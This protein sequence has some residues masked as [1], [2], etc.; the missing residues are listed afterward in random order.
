MLKL[1][2]FYL[3]DILVSRY[4]QKIYKKNPPGMGGVL[5][6]GPTNTGKDYILKI[7]MA[8][9]GYR[10]DK[11]YCSLNAGPFVDI[12]DVK[13]KALIQSLILHIAEID[14]WPSALIEGAFNDLLTSQVLAGLYATANGDEYQDRQ[15]FSAALLS[16]LRLFRHSDYSLE[17][18]RILVQRQTELKEVVLDQLRHALQAARLISGGLDFIPACA[19]AYADSLRLPAIKQ[20]VELVNSPYRLAVIQAYL[21]IH[22][23]SLQPLLSSENFPLSSL[24]DVGLRTLTLSLGI[25]QFARG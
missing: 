18:L 16:R 10:A 13:T 6:V 3:C 24:Y 1:A 22:H 11:N 2:G 12:Q 7:V 4:W 23:S 25:E 5:V 15:T 19:R 8:A 21:K 14:L 9:V 17:E 20:P